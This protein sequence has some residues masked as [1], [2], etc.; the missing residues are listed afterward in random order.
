[1]VYMDVSESKE[2]TVSNVIKKTKSKDE[3]THFMIIISDNEEN[4]Y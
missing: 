3:I 2:A 1:M 4:D